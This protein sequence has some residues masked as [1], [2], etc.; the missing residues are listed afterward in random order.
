MNA[1]TITSSDLSFN[2]PTDAE[3]DVCTG[4][5]R[6]AEQFCLEC[7]SLYCESHL[8]MHN[9]VHVGKRH[10]L[11][12]PT[13]SLNECICPKHD[14]LMEVFCRT[15]QQCICH[16][17]ILDQH[18][19]HDVVSVRQE[20]AEVQFKHGEIQ[21]E[22]T[23]K[24]Q[25]KEKEVQKLELAVKSFKTSAKEAVET[26][27]RVFTDMI[28]LIEKKRDMVQGLIFAQEETAEKKA[29]AFLERLKTEIT[30]LKRRDA[31]LQRLEKLSQINMDVNFLQGVLSIPS[32]AVSL[33]SP[34]VYF[35]HPYC[36]FQFATEAVSELIKQLD[37][38]CGLCLTKITHRVKEILDSTFPKLREDL[39]QYASKLTLNLNTAHPTLR[40]SDNNKEVTSAHFQEDYT[41][42]PD[43]FN[44]RAQILCN[45]GFHDGSHYWEVEYGGSCWVCIA[46]SYIRIPR[47]GKR[48]PLFGKNN[49]SWGLRCQAGS[50]VFWYNNRNISL[51]YDQ[52]CSRIGVYLDYGA[53]I[54]EFYNV[55]DNMSL[56]H[57]VQTNF[58]EPVYAGFGLAGK[59]TYIKI[60]DLDVK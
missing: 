23:D 1:E 10:K 21:R 9:I 35:V 48:G 19:A 2:S 31:E 7:G 55:L 12:E 42:H 58:K 22:I 24:I 28:H 18:K 45:E 39:L 17:C 59:G 4:R 8:D 53:G 50:Y 40:L 33:P 11:V 44:F 54:L 29:M 16:L 27:A 56:I 15:D 52:H 5:K 38:A 47:K 30:D 14:K 36:S 37:E 60:W 46:V 25:T 32:L 20:V 57:K 49:C 6:K 13:K 34:T 3:C 26:N 41:D 51:K 43:R